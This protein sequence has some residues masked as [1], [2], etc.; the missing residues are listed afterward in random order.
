VRFTP[1]AIIFL[2]AAVVFM[3]TSGFYLWKEMDEVNRKLPLGDRISFLGMYTNKRMRVRKLYREFYPK[4][5]L[6]R[7]ALGWEIAGFVSLFLA[8]LAS[9]M[10]PADFTPRFEPQADPV[11]TFGRKGGGKPPHSKVGW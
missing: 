6:Q 1:A 11:L 2:I 5:R 10:F 4:G 9:G 7:M 3:I 8:A